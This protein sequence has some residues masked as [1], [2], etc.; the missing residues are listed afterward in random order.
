MKKILICLTVILFSMVLLSCDNKGKD[1]PEPRISAQG[2]SIEETQRGVVS[3]F[4]NLRLRIESAGRI[5]QLRIQ[6]RS[7]DVD[8]ATTREHH[9]FGLFGLKKKAF[10][11]KDITLDFSHYI[12][13][14][15][16]KAGDY[17]FIIDVK[18]KYGKPANAILKIHLL[19]DKSR[20]TPIETGQFRLQRIGKGV[21]KNSGPFGISWK[22]VGEIR[23]RIRVSKPEGGASKLA[24]FTSDDYDQ[25]ASKEQLGKSINAAVNL[26]SIEFDT[27]NNSAAGQVLGINNLGKYYLLRVTNSET[28][29]SYVGTTVNL[30]G[31]FKY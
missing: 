14:K 6:E 23:V 3:H 2:F 12:N 27:S 13:S 31:E 22:T 26:T 1:L 4:G 24:R 11:H 30:A 28:E 29:L 7:Y 25:L 19:P 20:T 5:Q 9:H 21:V 8:L 18:D 17:Q 16:H 15:L 10:L